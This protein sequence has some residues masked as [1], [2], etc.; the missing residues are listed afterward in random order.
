M[1]I[2][3]VWLFALATL[4]IASPP[5]SHAADGAWTKIYDHPVGAAK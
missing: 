5:I 1:R 3:L 4:G 2:V